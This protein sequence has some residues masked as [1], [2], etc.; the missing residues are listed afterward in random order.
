MRFRS[1]SLALFFF[2]LPA[3]AAEPRVDVYGDPLPPG[4][5]ARLGRKYEPQNDRQSLGQPVFSPDGTTIATREVRGP[6]R[7]WNAT[8]GKELRQLVGPDDSDVLKVLTFAADGKFLVAT[9]FKRN[10]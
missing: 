7:L 3:D 10:F 8:T 2:V 6:I 4:A 1:A 9:V 5:I